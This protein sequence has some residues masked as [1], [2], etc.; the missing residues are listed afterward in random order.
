MFI[1][2]SLALSALILA[3]I[4]KY[5]QHHE[6]S[7]SR[8]YTLIIKLRE[9]VHLCRQHRSAVHYTFQN[10]QQRPIE[11]NHIETQ[12]K[13]KSD[14]LISMAHSDNKLLYRVYH[15]EIE[16]LLRRW[17][18]EGV[19]KNQ[20]MH[21][22]AIRDGMFLLDE[23]MVCW[24]SESHRAELVEDYHKNWQTVVDS[25]DQLTKL[26]VSIQYLDTEAGRERCRTECEFVCRK[27]NQLALVCPLSISSPMGNKAVRNLI[28]I[29]ESPDYPLTEKELYQLSSD[30][31]QLIF[32]VYDQVLSDISES[33]FLPLPR[34]A[35]A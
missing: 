9:I 30:V 20:I 13:K 11:L 14:E 18:D 21:G 2:I 24:L 25:M 27:L 15:S 16:L 29:A 33:L 31:S 7:L 5:S 22:K 6:A 26:R 34:L 32:N 12:L 17:A 3:G 1:L 23:L 35:F 4:Y 19:V 8:K 28:E 10:H